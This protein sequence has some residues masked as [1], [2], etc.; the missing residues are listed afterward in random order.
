MPNHHVTQAQEIIMFRSSET[1]KRKLLLVGCCFALAT[2][3]AAVA[4]APLET[5]P[6]IEAALSC[7]AG[8]HIGYEG[9]YCWPNRPRMC[10]RGYHLGYE[11][12]YCWPN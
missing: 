10:P 7:P 1:L 12:K 5:L 2:S 3:S 11:G 8:T 4:A 6:L 9:K